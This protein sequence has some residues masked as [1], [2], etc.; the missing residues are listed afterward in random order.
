LQRAGEHRR[1]VFT[2]DRDF[3]EIAREWIAAGR[4]FNGIVYARQLRVT[5][6]RAISDLQLI[7]EA[8]EPSEMLNRVIHL[9][10]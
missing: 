5:I 1:V 8:I 10:I 9:P 4:Q 7:S 3:L 6:G 2:Q